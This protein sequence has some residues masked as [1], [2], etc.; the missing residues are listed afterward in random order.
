MNL[1]RTGIMQP[2]VVLNIQICAPMANFG[3]A[4]QPTDFKDR[5]LVLVLHANTFLLAFGKV[6]AGRSGYVIVWA[7]GQGGT[8]LRDGRLQSECID[9]FRC[10]VRMNPREL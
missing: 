2:D 7:V 1:L 4:L 6:L 8:G 9:A 5:V 10:S 3:S